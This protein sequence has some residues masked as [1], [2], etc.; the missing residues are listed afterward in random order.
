MD[1]VGLIGA[2]VSMVAVGIVWYY[3]QVKIEGA[4]VVN[5]RKQSIIVA[6]IYVIIS[7]FVRS[8]F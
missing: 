6:L 4:Q 7:T 3:Y 8:F 1:I 5:A 2:V